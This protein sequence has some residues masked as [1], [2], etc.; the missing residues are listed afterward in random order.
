M[1][2]LPFDLQKAKAGHRLVTRV[3]EAAVTE[4]TQFQNA[5]GAFPCIGILGGNLR[6]FNTRGLC[7]ST[8]YDDLFLA[9]E[10]FPEPPA[11]E[12]WHNPRNSTPEQVGVRSGWRLRTKWEVTHLPKP[13]TDEVSNWTGDNFVT[14]FDDRRFDLY[15]TY[16]TRYPLPEI[17]FPDPPCGEEWHN[18]DGLSA[19]QVGVRDGWRLL[20]KSEVR[21]PRR[22]H[23][24][25]S[26]EMWR[27]TRWDSDGWS[28]TIQSATYRTKVPFPARVPLEAEDWVLGGPWWI[29]DG[30][31]NT[32]V[33]VVGV[34]NNT[35]AASQAGHYSHHTLLHNFKR[36]NDGKTW[37]PCSKEAK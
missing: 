12:Q 36:S 23:I 19:A 31:N 27:R 37:H 25:H 2:K 28:G 30:L 24:A 17:K 4:F 16:R 5:K 26:C 21:V 32:A 8:S 35:V 6:F 11:G 33:L 34:D 22:E 15:E 18:P 7:M 9:V 1:K 13:E 14:V 20:V 29:R 10:E 3:D